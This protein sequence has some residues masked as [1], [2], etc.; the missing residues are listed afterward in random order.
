MKRRKL[1]L[2][3]RKLFMSTAELHIAEASVWATAL[4]S[5]HGPAKSD[6]Y[7]RVAQK[8]SQIAGEPVPRSKIY[9]LVRRPKALKSIA[10]HIREALASAYAA[11]CARQQRLLDHE[12][13]IATAAG[14]SS[15]LISA[16]VGLVGTGL[17]SPRE[18]GSGDQGAIR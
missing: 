5:K 17:E 12:I 1:Y 6:P 9:S 14:A 16:A 11:E 3:G 13:A 7:L 4:V 10:S 18:C 2:F 8:A 15:A